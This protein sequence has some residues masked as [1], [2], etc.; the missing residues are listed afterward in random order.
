MANDPNC[1]QFKESTPRM[2]SQ[3][4]PLPR[5]M[6]GYPTFHVVLLISDSK[7]ELIFL[8]FWRVDLIEKL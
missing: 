8:S 4:R 3:I 6:L 2:V 1:A 7:N 5:W